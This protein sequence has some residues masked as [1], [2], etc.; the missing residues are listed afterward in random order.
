M[1]TFITQRATTDDDRRAL[2]TFQCVSQF[3][4]GFG[5][6]SQIIAQPFNLIGQIGLRTDC[7]NLRTLFADSFLDAGVHQRRFTT[8]V[9]A[10]QQDHIGIFDTCDHGVE[11][12][13][14]QR[15][16]VIG[17]AGLATF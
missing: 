4:G 10:H 13:R 14:R 12:H 2:R 8:Q 5:K 17:K 15:R 6:R 7:E 9:A 16:R 3:L 11:I 1:H